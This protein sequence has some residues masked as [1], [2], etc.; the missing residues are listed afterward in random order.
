MGH[1]D[2]YIDGEGYGRDS[3]EEIKARFDGVDRT[4]PLEKDILVY[5][6]E[7][8][9]IVSG[10]RVN[11]FDVEYK[12]ASKKIVNIVLRPASPSFVTMAGHIERSH[13]L[14][15]SWGG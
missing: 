6:V 12:G 5:Q 10:F 2:F 13:H 8:D 7:G 11:G 1:Y 15:L 3:I 14:V 4:N 9:H